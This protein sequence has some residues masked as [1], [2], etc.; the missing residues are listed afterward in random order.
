VEARAAKDRDRHQERGP[1]GA[2]RGPHD[3]TQEEGSKPCRRQRASP[4]RGH[5]VAAHEQEDGLAGRD[6]PGAHLRVVRSRTGPAPEEPAHHL[7]EGAPP[8]RRHPGREARKR[9]ALAAQHGVDE[10]VV[11]RRAVPHDVDDRSLAGELPDAFDQLLAHL[12]VGERE[13]D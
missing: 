8:D 7:D 5:R 1:R 6:E 9:Q 11:D 2:G 10:Q 13:P 12:D 4:A 3:L